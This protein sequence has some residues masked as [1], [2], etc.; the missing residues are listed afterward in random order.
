MNSPKTDRGRALRIENRAAR[1]ATD[2]A[3]N[4][5]LS[6]RLP[7]RARRSMAMVA[8]QQRRVSRAGANP[9]SRHV[10]VCAHALGVASGRGSDRAAGARLA[11]QGRAHRGPIFSAASIPSR[12]PVTLR[13]NRWRSARWSGYEDVFPLARP[14][15][16][17]G[18]GRRVGG[19]GQ[20]RL[21]WRGWGG[22]SACGAQR[23]PRDR[24]AA[25]VLCCGNGGWSGWTTNSQYRDTLQRG[26]FD[27]HA[28]TRTVDVTR[29]A[30]GSAREFSTCST[31]TGSCWCA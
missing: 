11:R 7:G 19:A 14:R 23:A 3:T 28:G 5:P 12:C 31:A 13:G 26:G 30:A 20:Q 8:E 4:A 17:A 6:P 22:V 9:P 27:L 21:V 16:R 18:G 24:D 25:P 1:R 2:H 29:D 10:V 15:Q